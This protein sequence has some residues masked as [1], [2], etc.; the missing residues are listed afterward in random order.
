FVLIF[1]VHV[2]H[3]LKFPNSGIR[4]KGQQA[5]AG[6]VALKHGA[7]RGIRLQGGTRPR[8][9]RK[10]WL[11]VARPQGQR[12]PVASPQRGDA[13]RLHRGSG[14]DDGAEREEEDLGHS[15]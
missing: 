11:P 2:M 10:G 14:S 4:V 1:T 3:R 7:R 9:G 13:R 12:L 8:P 5:P 6:T 15:Y